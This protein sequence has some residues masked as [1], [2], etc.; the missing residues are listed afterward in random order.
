MPL[1]RIVYNVDKSDYVYNEAQ[2]DK[3]VTSMPKQFEAD[4]DLPR[5]DRF[6]GVASFNSD[7]RA[8]LFAYPLHKRCSQISFPP[9]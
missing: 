7:Q 5:I 2:L 1:A 3:V 9:S 8:Q 4:N 6:K